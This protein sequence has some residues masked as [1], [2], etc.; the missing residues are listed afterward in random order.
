MSLAL[1]CPPPAACRPIAWVPDAEETTSVERYIEIPRLKDWRALAAALECGEIDSEH[2]DMR[3]AAARCIVDKLVHSR[4]DEIEFERNFRDCRII[5][6]HWLSDRSGDPTGEASLAI[7]FFVALSKINDYGDVDH[8]NALI[9]ESRDPYVVKHACRAL[10]ESATAA[11][12]GNIYIGLATAI[13]R[14]AQD[15]DPA[16]LSDHPV[17]NPAD[18][19]VELMRGSTGTTFRRGE[20]LQ[21]QDELKRRA[22][23]FLARQGTG[24]GAENLLWLAMF[25]NQPVVVSN[26]LLSLPEVWQK[27]VS[28]FHYFP[29]P[30]SGYPIHG[31]LSGLVKG[32][33]SYLSQPECHALAEV[34]TPSDA[35][36]GNEQLS[37]A[38]RGVCALIYADTEK[39]TFWLNGGRQVGREF[40]RT[41][42]AVE[43]SGAV[44]AGLLESITRNPQRDLKIDGHD[45]QGWMSHGGHDLLQELHGV[46]MRVGRHEEYEPLARTMARLAELRG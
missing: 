11:N 31:S 2:R 20:E 34:K 26:A 46:A 5:L 22:H 27:F 40:S 29:E 36:F 45:V 35:L 4:R 38:V 42:H 39:L 44:L 41:M 6:G 15:L 28:C 37:R 12:F 17:F 14:F 7:R 19:I 32:V 23:A 30:K 21:Q 33:A 9:E 3:R 24:R 10:W 13:E 8:L 16:C 43:S 18:A 1:V 25:R